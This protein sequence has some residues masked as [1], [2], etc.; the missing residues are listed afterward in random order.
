MGKAARKRQQQSVRERIAAQQAAARR[1]E[2]QRR[3]L[4]TGGAVVVV[5]AIVLTFVLIKLNSGSSGSSGSSSSVTGTA[6]PASVHRDVTTVP[7]ST[8]NTIGEG[9]V[10]SYNP[11][12]VSA[13]SGAALTSQGKPEIAETG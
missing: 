4:I 10:L 5:V 12:P 11:Q 1:A 3:L 7:V 9:T 8:L 13:I 6:L 2:A